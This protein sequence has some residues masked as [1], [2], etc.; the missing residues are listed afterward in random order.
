MLRRWLSVLAIVGVV[1]LV[2]ELALLGV[3]IWKVGLPIALALVLAKLVLGGWALQRE[4]RRGWRRF[5]DAAYA[6]RPLGPE[7]TDGAVGMFAALLV[8]L[9]GF[10]SAVV[11]GVVLIPPVRRW[12]ARVVG[13]RIEGRLTPDLAGSV[14][15][16]RRIKVRREGSIDGDVV[17][18]TPDPDRAGPAQETRV[19]EGE[20][21]PP[22]PERA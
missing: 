8:L 6:R 9:G 18:P 13:R 10:V 4:G 14:F 5:Q 19:L 3:V 17:T 21:L 7:A 16:P 11:G 20:I 1:V 12:V 22:P 2:G 15:G